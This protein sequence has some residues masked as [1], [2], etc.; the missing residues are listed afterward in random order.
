MVSRLLSRSA[1]TMIVLVACT[2]SDQTPPTTIPAA[3]TNP[4][5][6]STTTASTTT[7]TTPTTTQPGTE[8]DKVAEAYGNVLD[9]YNAALTSPDD[10][11]ARTRF[12]E[13]TSGDVRLSGLQI[14]DR[15]RG[16]GWTT[17]PHPTIPVGYTVESIDVSSADATLTVCK[18][19]SLATVD[20]KTGETINDEVSASRVEARFSKENSMWVQH[21]AVEL[22]LFEG[23]STCTD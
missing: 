10:P 7:S 6:T 19:N 12:I 18:I 9:A 8:E 14:I 3:P 20:A 4:P 5:V 23:A 2:G 15:F 13:L 1:I 11:V 16:N 17:R 21:R 22:A